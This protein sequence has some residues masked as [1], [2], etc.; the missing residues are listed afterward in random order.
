MLCPY[1]LLLALH[2]AQEE[3]RA[4]GQQDA[5]RRGVGGRGAHGRRVTEPG[6]RGRRRTARLAPQRH[7]LVPAFGHGAASCRVATGL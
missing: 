4:V 3:E 7:R 5:V 2:G 6:D 1:L